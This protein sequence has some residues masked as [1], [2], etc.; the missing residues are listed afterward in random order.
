[1]GAAC[2]VKRYYQ[3]G[4]LL[5]STSSLRTTVLF[6]SVNKGSDFRVKCQGQETVPPAANRLACSIHQMTVWVK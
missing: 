4:F 6:L 2:H 5:T 1:M 3:V